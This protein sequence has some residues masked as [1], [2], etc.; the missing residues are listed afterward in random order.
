MKILIA[1]ESL[2]SKNIVV[3]TFTFINFKI[4]INVEVIPHE[5]EEIIEPDIELREIN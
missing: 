5:V 3:L 1:L 2:C 4:K